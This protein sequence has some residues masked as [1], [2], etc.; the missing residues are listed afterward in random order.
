[1]RK[2]DN[3]SDAAELRRR[4]EA[5]LKKSKKQTE[6][7]LRECKKEEPRRSETIDETRRLVHELQVHQIE[8]EM[9]NDELL[10]TRAEFEALSA[11]YADLYEFAPVGY[12]SLGRDG[13]I[14]RTN[15]AAARLLSVESAR[16]VKRR[17]GLFVSMASR[18]AFNAFFEKAFSSPATEACEVEL[19]PEGNEPLQVRIEATASEDGQSCRVVMVDIT[20]R[21]RAEEA[22]L[23]SEAQL[24]NAWRIARAGHWEYDVGSDTFTF[25]D[26]FYQIFRT[27]AEEV[28][29][30]KMSS[31]DYARRFCHPDDA[32]LVG[33]E[34]QAAI[35]TTDP[36]YN[37]QFEHR[38][39]YANGEVGHIAVRFFIVKDR[40][41]R[42][43]RTFGVNQDITDRKQVESRL[44][45]SETYFR[46][47]VETS[48]DA[49]IIIDA[50]GLVSYGSRKAYE[51]FGIPPDH[52][53]TG[54]S[55]LNW[56]EPEDHEKVKKR[57][58]EILSG[59]ST[60]ETKEYRLLKY[61]REPFW[62]E[63]SSSSWPSAPGLKGRLLVIC[64][65]ITERKKAEEAIKAQLDELRRWYEVTVGRE[66]RIL[67]LKKEVDELL[68][69]TGQ[70]P[71]YPSAEPGN[72]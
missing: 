39:I 46:T 8:L 64:R 6:A 50:A 9:Q 26:N 10:R 35:E 57:L 15:L 65:D 43:V 55:M 37:R 21:K 17:F 62:G 52:S 33:K 63:L 25:N 68:R 61:D 24:S 70:P 42:T 28:G 51:M 48:P 49:I 18:P 69:Q 41:R 31:A 30:Y 13:T 67:D 60:P 53:A 14:R 34:V 2:D 3:A 58:V 29:G 45:E 22:L 36:D 23:T 72:P 27:T 4:A 20:E 5:W 47:L 19:K 56:V 7:K 44:L 40:Q 54:I 32:A 38:I 16:L 59:Q 71:R 11:Q 1:M 12:L 66:T